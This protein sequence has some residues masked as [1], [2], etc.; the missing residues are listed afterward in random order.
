M[1]GL[2][3]SCRGSG[4]NI[5]TGVK[6]FTNHSPREECGGNAFGLSIGRL[7]VCMSVCLSVR[8]CNSKTIAPTDLIPLPTKYYTPGSVLL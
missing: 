7:P 5:R 8:A 2:A 3:S 1:L 4:F 6:M